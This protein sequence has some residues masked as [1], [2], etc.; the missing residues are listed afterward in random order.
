MDGSLGFR[1]KNHQIINLNKSKNKIMNIEKITYYVATAV[2]SLIFL[3]SAFMYFTNY[4]VVLGLFEGFGFPGWLVYPLAV[5]KVLGVIAIWTRVS[6]LLKE[7]AYAG[8]FYDAVLALTVHMIA[9]DGGSLFSII[10]LVSL[11]I[12]RFLEGRVFKKS[13]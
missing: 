1:I 4:E 13:N 5:L 3:F 2:M 11:V 9:E 7:W 10:A 8:F 12:S 6:S